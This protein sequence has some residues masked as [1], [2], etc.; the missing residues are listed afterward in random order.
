M[1]N[2]KFTCLPEDFSKYAVIV[3]D[4]ILSYNREL[5]ISTELLGLA[6]Q[7]NTVT[8]GVF[9]HPSDAMDLVDELVVM[10]GITY[11]NTISKEMV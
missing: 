4:L 8:E 3:G 1:S 2:N 11:K 9:I 6:V 7:G 10:D 5:Q